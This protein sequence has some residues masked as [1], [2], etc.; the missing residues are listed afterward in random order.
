MAAR[1]AEKII[2]EE[3]H[4]FWN[5]VLSETYNPLIGRIPR[6]AEQVRQAELQRAAAVLERLSPAERRVIDSMTRAIVKK[7][8]HRPVSHA[9]QLARDGDSENL[10]RL[11]MALG[12]EDDDPSNSR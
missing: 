11:L 1:T 2:T 9:R 8:L 5:M 3:A 4:R 7:I 6:Q 12:P 10:F